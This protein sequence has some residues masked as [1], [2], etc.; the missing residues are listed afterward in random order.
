MERAL[1]LWR[2]LELPPL[3]KPLARLQLG[4]WSDRNREEAELALQGRHFEIG[5]RAKQDGKKLD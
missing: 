1:E 5:E 4:Y 2:R 3:Q